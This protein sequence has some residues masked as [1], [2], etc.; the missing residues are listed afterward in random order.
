M[1]ISFSKCGTGIEE[2]D[3]LGVDPLAK[4]LI[5]E[6]DV[7]I[8]E[9][10]S[11]YLKCQGFAVLVAPS[12]EAAI[13]AVESDSAV[14]LVLMDS[15]LGSR[16]EGARAAGVI[17]GK[18]AIPV[19]IL[20]FPMD[21]KA[22]GESDDA[23]PRERTEDSLRESNALMGAI[24]AAAQDAIILMGNKGEITFWNLAAERIFGYRAEEALGRDLHSLIA[25]ERYF[26]R[27]HDAVERFH[28]TG[29]GEA[30]GTVS[31]VEALVKGGG[32]IIVEMSLAAVRIHN[33]WHAIGVL[34]DVTERK[35]T[36]ESLKKM[37]AEKEILL[38]EVHHRIKNNM[39]T[40]SSLLSLQ[41]SNSKEP[42][43][44][45]ALEDANIRLGSMVVLYDKLY[46]STNFGELS[47]KE[48][49]DQLVDEI[50]A[51]F[52]NRG[53]VVIEKRIE[54]LAVDAKKLQTLGII[55]NELLTN[56]MKH[57][58]AGR[59]RGS[60]SISADSIDERITLVIEDDGKGIPESV[61]FENSA[62]FGLTLVGLLTKQLEGTI[63][64]KRV[65]GTRIVLV[66]GRR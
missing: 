17:R 49:L 22:W 20:P 38:K 23:A 30:L 58:F 46:K 19:I 5:V 60:I 1:D 34:R 36:D 29:K 66:F 4:I 10:A 28:S 6:E 27:Y 48:Y 52:P 47:I 51:N 41:A 33:G 65:R 25:P 62:G 64:I 50:M 32:E 18:H 59:E 24:T 42:A 15:D 21:R 45:R 3:F 37:L 63:Q 7:A 11:N 31:E 57:A 14:S 43:V 56:I 12:C 9:N 40:V 2:E 8:A 35:K 39:T 61:D 54:D 53:S 55:V 16:V 44:A 26:S 13:E